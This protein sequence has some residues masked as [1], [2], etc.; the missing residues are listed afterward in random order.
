MVDGQAG[1]IQQVAW[2]HVVQE[3]KCTQGAAQT[4]HHKM[5]VHFAILTI[6]QQ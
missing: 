5:G 1:Q 3:A 6:H 2:V 4:H